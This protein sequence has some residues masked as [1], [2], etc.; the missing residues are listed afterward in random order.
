MTAIDA[1][2]RPA[3]IFLVKIEGDVGFLIRVGQFLNAFN[4]LKP[5]TWR[6]TWKQAV[7]EH[8]GI[9]DG[10]GRVFEAEVGGFREAPLSE[11]DGREITWS[12]G[13]FSLDGATRYRIL[14]I[15]DSLKGRKYSFLDYV[16]LALHRFHIYVPGLKGYI[17]SSRHLICSQA[18]DLAY[19][20]AGVHLFDDGRWP[21]YVDPLDL[22]L[23]FEARRRELLGEPA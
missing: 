13:L 18:A 23:L 1:T 5:W 15:C 21:G 12:S 2:I 14:E 6:K 9:T 19:E 10:L 16:A 3:D 11:Y 4:P 22:R 20:L 17:N 7:T 8:A